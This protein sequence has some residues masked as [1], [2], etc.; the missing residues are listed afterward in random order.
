MKIR[1]S[2]PRCVDDLRAALEQAD[3]VAARSADDTVDVSFPWAE[4]EDEARQAR[5]E[6]TFF[7]KAWLAQNPGAAAL[8]DA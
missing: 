4:D 3:C 6:A 1:L 5:L 8:V 2:N 7:V